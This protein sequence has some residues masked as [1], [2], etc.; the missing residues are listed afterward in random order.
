MSTRFC[1]EFGCWGDKVAKQFLK[2]HRHV[3]RRQAYP[4]PP[5]YTTILNWR[6]HEWL[7]NRR[8]QRGSVGTG[9]RN[10]RGRPCLR[11]T[12]I[13]THLQERQNGSPQR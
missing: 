9:T 10:S 5:W 2:W 8:S 4:N 12:D 13:V 7:Q 11:Y 1:N 6:G 3:S